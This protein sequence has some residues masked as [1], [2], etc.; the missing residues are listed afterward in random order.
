MSNLEQSTASLH[1]TAKKLSSSYARLAEVCQKASKSL[2][3]SSDRM[4][5]VKHVE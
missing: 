2:K 5:K 3:E 4:K 1:R